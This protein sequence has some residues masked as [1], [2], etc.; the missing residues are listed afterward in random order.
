MTIRRHLKASAI[1]APIPRPG[2]LPSIPFSMEADMAQ[3]VKS[4]AENGFPFCKQ[5]VRVFLGSY[6]Q[7][8]WDADDDIGAYLRANCQFNN[9]KTPSEDWM[10]CFV[11]THYLSLKKPSMMEK[12]RKIASSDPFLIYEFFDLLENVVTAKHLENSPNHIFNLDETAFFTDPRSGKVV[13]E[14]GHDTKRVVAGTG[15]TCFTAMAC[16]STA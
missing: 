8:C 3:L 7:Q 6:I 10:T 11:D 4:A 13:S 5:E 12:S 14:V 16:V 9:K 15:R 1:G 2:R